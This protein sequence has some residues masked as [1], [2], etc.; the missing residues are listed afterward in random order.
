MRTLEW[1]NMGMK[2]DGR[3]LHH[4]RFASDIALITPNISQAKRMLADFD[5]AC[6]EIGLR[7]N[8]VKTM[9]MMRN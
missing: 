4:V 5:K 9:C 7:L 1:D 6:A 8:V 3:Q 2:I